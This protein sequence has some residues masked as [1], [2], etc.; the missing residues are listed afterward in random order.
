MVIWANPAE[1]DLRR[2]DRDVARRVREAVA[3][4]AETGEGDIARLRPPAAGYCLRVGDWRVL[5]YIDRQAGTLTVRA[6]D[7]RSRIYKQH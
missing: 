2:L 3:R 6:V 5:V 4:F 7:H 1:H